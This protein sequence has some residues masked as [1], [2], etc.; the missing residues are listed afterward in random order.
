M[1]LCQSEDVLKMTGNKH[2]LTVLTTEK[3]SHLFVNEGCIILKKKSLVFDS[4]RIFIFLL[5][6]NS[7]KSTNQS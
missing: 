3:V 4:N 5:S 7:L 6:T 2:D 1:S